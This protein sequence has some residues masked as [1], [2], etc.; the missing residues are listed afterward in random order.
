MLDDV[1]GHHPVERCAL[2]GRLDHRVGPAVLLDQDVVD[3][4]DVLDDD[5]GVH[6][7]VPLDQT[8]AVADVEVA[9]VGP[10]ARDQ[11]SVEGADLQPSALHEVAERPVELTTTSQLGR[12]V[13]GLGCLDA[14][15]ASASLGSVSGGR[16]SGRR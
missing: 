14:S 5:I 13:D 8:F 11:G 6:L 9:H 1:R 4:D 15:D 7:L 16:A 2:P 10:V 3:L 12:R